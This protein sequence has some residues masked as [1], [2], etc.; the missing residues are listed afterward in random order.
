M[1]QNAAVIDKAQTSILE[2]PRLAIREIVDETGL[3][4]G[5]ANMILT[6]DLGMRRGVEK[7]VPKL[8]LPEQQQLRLGRAAHAGVHQQGS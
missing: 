5:S 2:D 1:S 4:R 7:F 8:L 6:E 3:S